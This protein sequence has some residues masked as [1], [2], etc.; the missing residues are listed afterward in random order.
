MQILHS[1][2]YVCCCYYDKEAG[3]SLPSSLVIAKC[4]DNDFVYSQLMFSLT[5][6]DLNLCWA[7]LS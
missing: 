6:S 7:C 2:V 5:D 4:I 1:V 3:F